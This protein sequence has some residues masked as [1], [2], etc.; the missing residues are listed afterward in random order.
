MNEDLSPEDLRAA[1]EA[2]VKVVTSPQYL[3]IAAEINAL[4]EEEREAATLR[5]LTVDALRE[6]GLEVPEGLRISPRWFEPPEVGLA[7]DTAEVLAHNSVPVP[8]PT[9][10]VSV[11]F[12]VCVSYG[13][14]IS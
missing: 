2:L 3:A 5:L 6:R 9:V 8:P 10:C 12:I 11:G 13:Q 4:P 7:S 14:P 1:S